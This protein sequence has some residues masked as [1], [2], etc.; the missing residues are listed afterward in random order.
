MDFSKVLGGALW[1]LQRMATARLA[2]LYDR[3]L[4]GMLSSAGDP[5]MTQRHRSTSEI[6]EL[7]KF[8][9][10]DP[11]AALVTHLKSQ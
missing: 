1:W 4:A 3:I 8:E 6:T 10:T 9:I 11:N 5:T 2:R 7:L